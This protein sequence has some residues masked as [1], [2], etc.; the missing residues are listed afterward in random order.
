MRS[1]ILLALIVFACCEDY[2]KEENV[3]VLTDDTFDAFI[4]SHDHVLVKFYAPW[5]GHCKKLAPEYSKAAV[6]LEKEELYLAQVDATVQKKLAEKYQV[7]GYPTLKLFSKGAV[8]EYNGGR[9]EKDIIAWM[10]KKTG[11]ATTPLKTVEEVEKFK[12]D[13]EV[14]VIYFGEDKTQLEAFEK[15]ARASEEI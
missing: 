12:G 6:V 15:V 14:V 3:I 8:I 11:P 2:P 9:Q 10:K 7:Q 1:L 13:N 5:C 4:N